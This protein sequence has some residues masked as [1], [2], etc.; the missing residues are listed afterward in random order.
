MQKKLTLE[1]YII[2]KE[3]EIINGT[4]NHVLKPQ[5]NN[6]GYYRVCIG[7]KFYF[8]HR[9][10]AEKYVPNPENKEQVNH[11]DGNKQNNNYTNL[12]WVSN[13]ENR[14]HAVKN[15]LHLSGEQCSWS[16]LDWEKVDYIRT[17]NEDIHK[18]AE[19]FNVSKSTIRDVLNYRTWKNR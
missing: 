2:T 17:S 13:Q 10:V 18:L 11:K 3:G 6:K 7:G 14:T 8:V 1:D 4:N 12:E 5:L 15:K 16:K 9:L 19:K